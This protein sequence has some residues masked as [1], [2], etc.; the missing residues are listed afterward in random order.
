MHYSTECVYSKPSNWNKVIL[1]SY[2]IRNYDKRDF[3]LLYSYTIHNV[4]EHFNYI[5]L[6]VRIFWKF[7]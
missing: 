4:V 5:F 1:L 3:E 7:F 2:K 6:L